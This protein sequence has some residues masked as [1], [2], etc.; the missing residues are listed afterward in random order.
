LSSVIQK[1]FFQVQYRIWFRHWVTS[2][3][4]A[5]SIPDGVTGIFHSY[6][7]YSHT[8]TQRSIRHLTEMITRIISWGVKVA[9]A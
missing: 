2:R 4:V 8:V 7:P 3:Q 5:G 1:Y 6:N 9:G